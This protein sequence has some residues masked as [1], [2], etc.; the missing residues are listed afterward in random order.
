[1]QYKVQMAEKD[2]S[3][4]NDGTDI[5]D[6]FDFLKNKSEG[7]SVEEIKKAQR[8]MQMQHESEMQAMSMS[9]KKLQKEIGYKDEEVRNFKLQ[10][11]TAIV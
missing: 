5:T 11:T 1:M 2:G 9:L 6:T 3:L 4:Q 7:P 10:A 8:E